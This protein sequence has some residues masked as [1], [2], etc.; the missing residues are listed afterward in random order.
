[1]FADLTCLQAMNTYDKLRMVSE[2]VLELKKWLAQDEY[3]STEARV[4][5]LHEVQNLPPDFRAQHPGL[6]RFQAALYNDLEL[7]PGA[8]IKWIFYPL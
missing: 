2:P 8:A 5:L 1:M 6:I 3:R 4:T 7:P